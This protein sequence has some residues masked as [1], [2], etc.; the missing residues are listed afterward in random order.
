MS[1]CNEYGGVNTEGY[2]NSNVALVKMPNAPLASAPGSEYHP[3]ILGT[4]GDH[5]GQVNRERCMG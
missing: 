5:V 3:P 1:S 2:G 4:L